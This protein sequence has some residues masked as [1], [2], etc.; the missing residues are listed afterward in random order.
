MVRYPPTRSYVWSFLWFL[1][2]MLIFAVGARVFWKR[3]DDESARLFFWL[4]IVT[5]GAYMGGYHWTEIVVEPL[6]IYPFAVFA[7]S[8]PVVSL[9]FYLVFP[10]QNP[11]F[12][13]I[14]GGSWSCSTGFRRSS[15][16]PSGGACTCRLVPAL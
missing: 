11:F 3:P 14:A 2:E 1:Q 9:H 4:C 6:L 5:V 7:S 10:A 16:L 13:V 12:C 15:S 8:V